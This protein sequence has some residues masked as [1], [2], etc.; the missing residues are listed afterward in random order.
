MDLKNLKIQ[1]LAAKAASRKMALFSTEEKNRILTAIVESL[2]A[3]TDQ[4]L[5][6][7]ERDLSQG[8]FNRL[9]A[10]FLDRIM[11]NKKRL[12]AICQDVMNVAALSDFVG[13]IVDEDVRPN[14]LRLQRVRVPFGAILM[15]YEA[16]PNVTVDSAVLCLKSGNAV[17]LRG[18]KEAFETNRT[19]VK[20][21]RAALS[22]S[23]APNDAVQFIETT[24]RSAVTELLQ[25]KG[26]IDLVI[27]R[28][29]QNLI[30]HV[31]DNSKI[32]WIETG[33]SPVHIFVDEYAN[34]EKSV[35]VCVNAKTRRVSI[36]NA[37][38]TLLLDEKIAEKFL[39]K[40]AHALISDSQDRAVPL[41]ELRCDEKARCI[42]ESSECGKEF[43]KK[44]FHPYPKMRMLDSARDYDTE[45]LDSILNVRVI[46]H[47]DQALEHIAAH[48][49]G[50]SEAILTENRTRAELFLGRV[51][52]AC[53]YVNASPQFSDGAQFGLGAEIGISTQK[54]HVRGPFAL[55][56][57][58][59][60]KWK[61]YGDYQIRPQ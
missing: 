2:R 1:V 10:S 59:T 52:S 20:I 40:F 5:A 28:G 35:S 54:L 11:L 44:S 43:C 37:L 15:I 32:P 8:R 13:K 42:L 24:E 34:I 51:D 3:H 46:S 12:D 21:I 61:I 36:C 4:V 55:E 50:H 26:L 9:D 31:C 25:M 56:G 49:R 6:A 60:V 38:D 41:T 17:I 23:D 14:G 19:F 53:V 22:K 39:R 45:F 30:E 16:R 47:I 57:L 7:N 29:G 48:S 58:T 18:G 27:P 33:S